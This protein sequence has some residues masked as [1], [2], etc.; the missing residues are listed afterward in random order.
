MEKTRSSQIMCCVIATVFVFTFAVNML[1]A[2]TTP[3]ED[4]FYIYKDV[5]YAD[6]HFTPSGYMGDVGDITINNAF[7]KGCVAETCIQVVYTKKG[8]GPNKCNYPA[9]CKWAGVYW[10]EPPNNWCDE[11]LKDKGIA[12]LSAY[13]RLVFAAKA[14]RNCKIEFKVGGLPCDSLQP[15]RSIV[16]ELTPEWK[17]FTIDLS[18]ANLTHIVGGF[19]WATNWDTNPDGATFYLDNIRFEK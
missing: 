7:D 10:Q 17:D 16:A 9:P 2:Q 11:T 14:E 5:N 1:Q 13:T 19:V 15:P 18:G 4:A 8:N 12:A 6:N 3:A